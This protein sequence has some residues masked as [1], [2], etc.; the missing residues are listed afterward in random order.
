MAPKMPHLRFTVFFWVGGVDFGS[1]A[2]KKKS[3]QCKRDFFEKRT[4]KVAIF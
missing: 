3:W 1:V 4:A 2:T